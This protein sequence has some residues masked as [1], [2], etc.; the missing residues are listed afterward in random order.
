MSNERVGWWKSSGSRNGCGSWPLLVLLGLLGG[1]GRTPLEPSP[2]ECILNS[3]PPVKAPAS[4]TPRNQDTWEGDVA[5]AIDTVTPERWVYMAVVESE[6]GPGS[7][8]NADEPGRCVH[9]Q[10]IRVYRSQ[11]GANWDDSISAELP[12]TEAQRAAEGLPPD[13]LFGNRGRLNR[14]PALAVGSDGTAYL[15]FMERGGLVNCSEPGTD[16]P[17]PTSERP[18]EIQLWELRPGQ[19]AF[20]KVACVDEDGNLNCEDHENSLVTFRDRGSLDPNTTRLP[21]MDH[22]QIAVDPSG[23]RIV[24]T[25]ALFLTGMEPPRARDVIVTL[26]R[27]AN[28]TWTRVRPNGDQQIMPNPTVL[29]GNP[30]NDVKYTSFP[31]PIFDSQGRLYVASALD[32]AQSSTSG[33]LVQ[34]FTWNGT[35]TWVLDPSGS[36]GPTTGPVTVAGKQALAF[37]PTGATIPGLLPI[38]PTPAIAIASAGGQES[39]FVAYATANGM[40]GAS[41][42][43]SGIQIARAPVDNLA[44]GWSVTTAAGASPPAWAPNISIDPS[45]STLDLLYFVNPSVAP[46]VGIDTMFARFS[47]DTFT[48]RAG[49][50]KLNAVPENTLD[51]PRVVRGNFALTVFAGDHASVSTSGRKAVVGWTEYNGDATFG[52]P[53]ADATLGVVGSLCEGLVTASGPL[54]IA[55]N[56]RP[57]T[58]WEC[59]CSCGGQA[60]SLIGCAL[61]SATSA[62]AACSNVCIGSDCGAALTCGG[63]RAC[64]STGVGRNV[65]TQG[66]NVAWGPA[67]GGQP[68][69]FADYFATSLEDSVADF[70][71]GGEHASTVLDGAVA[72]NVAGGV[73]RAGAE[74]E[75]ARLAINPRS[76]H[77]G[78]TVGASVRSIRLVHVER[79]R[80]TFIDDR[81]FEIPA[82]SNELLM[83]FV[84]DPDGPDFLTGDPETRKI[85]G[86]NSEPLQGTLDLAT[87]ELFLDISLGTTTGIDGTFHGQLTGGPV[88]TDGDGIPD[89]ADICPAVFNP[90]QTDAPP[91]FGPIHDVTATVCAAGD[92]VT[93]MPPSAGDACTPDQ[94]TV[95]GMLISS[96]G[97]PY[98]PPRLLEDNTAVLPLGS[99]VVEWE[100]KDGNNLSA[101][102]RQTIRVGMQAPLH[103]TVASYL[104]DRSRVRFAS[105]QPA[106]VLNSGRIVTQIGV[107]AN[108]GDVSSVPPVMV[109]DRARVGAIRS[110]AGIQVGN[111]VITGTRTPNTQLVLAPPLDLSSVTF[112]TAHAG[113]VDVPSGETSLAPGS[114]GR[115]TVASGATLVLRAGT[116]FFG[117]LVLYPGSRILVEDSFAP[118]A[119]HVKTSLV[120]QGSIVDGAGQRKPVFVG[121]FGTADV[122]LEREFTGTLV[123]PFATVRLGA[124]NELDFDGIFSAG[125]LELRP[126]AVLTCRASATS[127]GALVPATASTCTDQSENGAETDVDCGGYVCNACPNGRRCDF[128]E[129][130]ASRTCV[131][132]V[133]SAS[134]ALSATFQVTSSWAG[135]YCGNLRVRNDGALPATHFTVTLDT[136]A[137]TITNS[138]GGAFTR[139]SG[140]VRVTPAFAFNQG[141]APGATHETIGFCANRTVS[142]SG[143]LPAIVNTGG[144]F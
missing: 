87:G 49:P 9:E 109:A 142:G 93:L 119:I 30:Q 61:A 7:P 74:I 21:D 10:A 115:A 104:T 3:P 48:K 134:G 8:M 11:A 39:I 111:G 57:D 80:G 5:S 76:F 102:V 130:C 37:E 23:N 100:A 138:W 58:V 73:P 63:P 117:H 36:G 91:V 82:G 124:D 18:M 22:P 92:S 79:L 24:I 99:T 137:S 26:E 51:M 68:T 144:T 113:D 101:T 116:Y 107:E 50:T 95:E 71:D 41:P 139:S 43:L 34:R 28:G 90:D 1:C 59:D 143:V 14:Q 88:D 127:M 38:N 52:G 77:A 65:F 4:R 106:P 84:V 33:P 55:T 131:T 118:V 40:D 123:A 19:A 35:D 94:V 85:V 128:G 66:C 27:A 69:L 114:Y 62:A 67:A 135:G 140:V 120:Y 122:V 121:F 20:R 96:N 46:A 56:A 60:S 141:I 129:D 42:R 75:I 31:R 132:G 16:F 29:Q 64:S 54:T 78:G 108:V 15:T 13:S 97:V 47:T 89:P 17:A 112:P 70:F 125:S 32:Q 110:E 136:R 6:T 103:T 86:S 53:N 81:H 2:D 105:G 126:D 83:S 12:R 25:H 98:N 72:L 45:T 133:C 44:S